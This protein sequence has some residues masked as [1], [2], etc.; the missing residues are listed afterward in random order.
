MHSETN[1]QQI[2]NQ[3]VWET[4][5]IWLEN[6]FDLQLG[7]ERVQYLRVKLWEFSAELFFQIDI[8]CS[9]KFSELICDKKNVLSL[10]STALK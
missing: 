5:K 4:S 8:P 9:L 10:T 7:K 3:G 6:I 2:L 1:N